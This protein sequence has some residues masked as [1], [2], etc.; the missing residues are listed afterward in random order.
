MLHEVFN[1]LPNVSNRIKMNKQTEQNNKHMT[2][3]NY[4]AQIDAVVINPMY[5]DNETKIYN[6]NS[7][8]LFGALRPRGLV[9]TD[10]PYNQKFG[11]DIYDDDLTDAQYLEL[12][13][14]FRANPCVFIHYPEETFRYVA[15]VMGAPKEVVTWVYNSNTKKQSRLITWYNCKPDFSRIKQPYKNLTD[16]R[17]LELIKN[18][19]EGSDI[20]DWWNVEQVKNVSKE[21]TAHPCQIPEEIYRR[22]ILTTT[23]IGDMIIDPFMGSGTALKV[24]KELGRKAIG[25]EISPDYCNIARNRISQEAMQYCKD[26]GL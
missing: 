9:I 14:T 15:Q 20:Y 2:G 24:A 18:G 19:S 8:L 7:K 11:Y 21:K 5:K 26:E 12:L 4:S 16:K 6:A 23:E 1:Y 10:P 13:A 17:I 25:I 3:D 22:I